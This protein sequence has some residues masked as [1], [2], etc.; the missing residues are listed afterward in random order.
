VPLAAT[1]RFDDIFNDIKL[2][3]AAAEAGMGV[4]QVVEVLRDHRARGYHI[5]AVYLPQ[6]RLA[7][8]I[9]VFMDF[10]SA[11][12][13]PPPWADNAAE[14]VPAANHRPIRRA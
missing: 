9:R 11:L 13:E 14:R 1:S 7:P 5:S 6:Q 3:I 8:K 10:L 12:F 4:I 2:L